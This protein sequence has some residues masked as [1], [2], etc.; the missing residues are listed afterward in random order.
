VVLVVGM[1]GRRRRRRRSLE[2]GGCSAYYIPCY[3]R[4]G[5]CVSNNSI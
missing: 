2:E 3:D 5:V 1:R 4:E